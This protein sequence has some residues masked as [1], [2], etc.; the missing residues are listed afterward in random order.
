MMKPRTR[1]GR[2]AQTVLVSVALAVA[3][4]LA[5]YFTT[6]NYRVF[7]KDILPF[8]DW[9]LPLDPV[10]WLR[11]GIWL[12]LVTVVAY[13]IA[14]LYA[15]AR[16]WRWVAI[17]LFVLAFILA[18]GIVIHSQLQNCISSCAN[19]S[20]F[21]GTFEFKGDVPLTNS[22]EFADFLKQMHGEDKLLFTRYCPGWR[23]AGT[24]TGVV[25]VGGGIHLAAL[26][27]TN[28]LVA[29]CSWKC[30]PPPYD[31][32]HYLMWEWW[33]V[34]NKEYRG[35]FEKHGADTAD[36]IKQIEHA[37]QQADSGTVPYSQEAVAILRYELTER[38][39]LW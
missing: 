35:I 16:Y 5:L 23:R 4:L 22:T 31:H 20:S 38:Q 24:K 7:F 37:L 6:V 14:T 17:L 28:V 19:H 12:L 8:P 1:F 34:N 30:H 2:I 13:L 3:F 36:M 9:R 33:N 21:W 39:E 15:R 32:Q 26:R 11:I 25:F 29:F 10:L 18:R 27:G